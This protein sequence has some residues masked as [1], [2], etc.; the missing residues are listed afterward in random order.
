MPL[1]PLRTLPSLILPLTP[2]TL[3]AA[4]TLSSLVHLPLHPI[5]PPHRR[6]LHLQITPT[7]V[8]MS[9]AK[10]IFTK[11]ACPREL[12]HPHNSIGAID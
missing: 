4:C 1:A 12:L 10:P 8:R 5:S 7:I 11:D 6:T 9:E 3:L 2:R